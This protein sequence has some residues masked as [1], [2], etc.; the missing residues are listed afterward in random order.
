MSNPYHTLAIAVEGSPE[1]LQAV[2][3]IQE[4]ER[5]EVKAQQNVLKGDGRSGHA[6][7]SHT[8]V[9]EDAVPGYEMRTPGAMTVGE[10]FIDHGDTVQIG[11][12]RTSREVAEGLRRTMGADEWKEL[13]GLPYE[14][15]TLNPNIVQDQVS[16][17]KERFPHKQGDPIQQALDKTLE[18]EKL[19]EEQAEGE[20]QDTDNQLQS[21]EPS[22]LEK[23]LETHYGPDMTTNLQRAVVES[24]EIDGENLTKL[25]VTDEMVTEAVEHY[26]AA[27]QAMLEPVGSCTAYLENFLTEGEAQ[28]ARAAIVGKDMSE[29]QR[30]GMVARDRAAGMTY[31]EASEFLTKEERLSIKLR[32]QGNLVIVTLPHVGDTSWGAAVTNGLISFR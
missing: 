6:Y 28:K 1:H 29:L 14:S 3:D 8:I 2:A 15:L 27:A 24:G 16:K 19:A 25:G 10:G 17:P 13:T 7:A 12:M 5:A 18:L 30:L 32:Q 22:L 23:V 31:A 21:Y 11:D 4:M 9:P 26:R 20:R